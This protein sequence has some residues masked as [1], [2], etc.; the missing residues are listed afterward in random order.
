MTRVGSSGVPAP[1]ILIAKNG[2]GNRLRAI[3]SA[4]QLSQLLGPELL[5]FWPPYDGAATDWDDLFD[6][7]REFTFINSREAES[8]G[9]MD[10]EIPQGL[11]ESSYMVT[12]RGGGVGEQI[13][14]RDFSSLAQK[15]C[16]ALCVVVSG[17]YFDS[18]ARNIRQV[19]RLSASSRRHLVQHLPIKSEILELAEAARPVGPYIGLHLRGTDRRKEAASPQRLT[20]IAKRVATRQGVNEVFICADSEP[21]RTSAVEQLSG[22]GLQVHF[23]SYLP[24]RR[25]VEGEKHALADFVNL[26]SST[27]LVGALASTFAT[28]AATQVAVNQVRLVRRRSTGSRRLD[29]ALRKKLGESA[30]F[31]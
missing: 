1:L 15:N 21:L 11:H 30:A 6:Q 17:G 7:P 27:H 20:N 16:S 3:A 29:K 28:E 23:D 2:L 12:L 14:I 5:V 25:D 10:A 13:Y 9:V 4:S 22:A 26:R 18:R 31:W 8:R 19:A 24:T